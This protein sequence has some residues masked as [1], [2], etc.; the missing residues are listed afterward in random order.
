M[1]PQL[2][3]LPRHRWWPQEPAP[4]EAPPPRRLQLLLPVAERSLW[5]RVQ[6][7]PSAESPTGVL[8]SR[9]AVGDKLQPTFDMV[10]TGKYGL[11]TA[12][13]GETVL[14]RLVEVAEG[15][16]TLLNI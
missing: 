13:D 1:Q 15:Q 11:F 2:A 14:C 12:A 10:M 3:A 8:A 6:L 7:P 5:L 9:A 4:L 16:Y